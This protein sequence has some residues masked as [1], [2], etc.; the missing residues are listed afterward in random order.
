MSKTDKNIEK[1]LSLYTIRAAMIILKKFARCGLPQSLI[2]NTIF[3]IKTCLSTVTAVEHDTPRLINITNSFIQCCQYKHGC[4]FK[5]LHCQT[6]Y[7]RLAYTFKWQLTLFKLKTFLLMACTEN[8]T[9]PMSANEEV[10]TAWGPAGDSF[11]GM[12][13]LESCLDFLGVVSFVPD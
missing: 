11:M 6:L 3:L 12:I 13:I 10:R 2:M 9:Y 7:L 5:T 1:C 4:L 8:T